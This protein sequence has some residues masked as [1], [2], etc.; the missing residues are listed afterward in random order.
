[1]SFITS[2]CFTIEPGETATWAAP[3]QRHLKR[4]TIDE[5]QEPGELN[6]LEIGKTVILLVKSGKLWIIHP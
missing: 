2:K 5:I 3:E 4:I 6:P 1:M